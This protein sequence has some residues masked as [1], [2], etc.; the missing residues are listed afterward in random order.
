MSDIGSLVKLLGVVFCISVVLTRV[1][2]QSA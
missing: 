1:T 2:E